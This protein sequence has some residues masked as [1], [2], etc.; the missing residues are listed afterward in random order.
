MAN[1]G[2]KFPGP[3]RCYWITRRDHYSIYRFFMPS[4]PEP[5]NIVELVSFEPE[6]EIDLKGTYDFNSHEDVCV[7]AQVMF[8]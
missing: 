4:R 3:W 5:D 7:A 6:P 1:T 2:K 8:A